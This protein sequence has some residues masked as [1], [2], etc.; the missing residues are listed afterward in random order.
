M[1]AYAWSPLGEIECGP[2]ANL[3][4][5]TSCLHE[6]GHIVNPCNKL[7]VPFPIDGGKRTMCVTCECDSWLWVQQQARPTWTRD[8]H[9]EMVDALRTYRR[10]G[11]PTQQLEIDMLT[12]NSLKNLASASFRVT[13]SAARSA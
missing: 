7:H 3:R 1:N 12:S 6:A 10:Y 13:R 8:M 11:T 9:D 4:G 5:Y 2:I